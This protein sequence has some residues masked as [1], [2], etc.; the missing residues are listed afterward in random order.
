MIILFSLNMIFFSYKNL[1]EQ[2]GTPKLL[3]IN[4][5]LGLPTKTNLED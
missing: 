4:N 1:V 2:G 5:M 3:N